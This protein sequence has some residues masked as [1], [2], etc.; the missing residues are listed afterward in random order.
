MTDVLS[1]AARSHLIVEA[2][3]KPGLLMAPVGNLLAISA[4]VVGPHGGGG[5]VHLAGN[6]DSVW[7]VGRT[8]S[9]LSQFTQK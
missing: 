6:G 3:M 1:S 4:L 7:P 2:I 5:L 8:E 9:Y